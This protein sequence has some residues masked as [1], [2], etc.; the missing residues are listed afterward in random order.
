MGED[1]GSIFMED[2]AIQDSFMIKASNFSDVAS[3]WGISFSFWGGKGEHNFS[4]DVLDIGEKNPVEKIGVH[5]LKPLLGKKALDWIKPA[6]KY[7]KTQ[8]LVQTNAINIQGKTRNADEDSLCQIMCN[9]NIVESNLQKVVMLHGL[10]NANWAI[11]GVHKENYDRCISYFTARKLVIPTWINCKDE[12]MIPDTNHPAY[13]QWQSDCVVYSLFNTASNQSSLRSIEYNG[14]TWD[15][16]NEF[17][18]MSYRDIEKLAGGQYSKDDINTVIEDDIEKFRKERFVYTKL[19]EV[20]LSPDA[21]AVLDKAT[22]LV[23]KSF[24][25]RKQ[26]NLEHP[27]Y[28]IN[29]WDAGWYQIKGMLKQY[30]PNELKE[31]NELYKRLED[32]M[33]PLVYELGFLYK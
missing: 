33:R 31:F 29:T 1:I 9:M 7:N 19:Q 11:I 20:T 27:E 18:W 24:K 2:C 17:F 22:E 15:I 21:Q 28:H 10:T 4:V 3:N 12:Y 25:Y 14:K 16:Q 26:F 8:V 30:M 6:G 5:S 13:S 23:V 32:R